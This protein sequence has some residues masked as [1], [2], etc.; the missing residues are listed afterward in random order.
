MTRGV[1]NTGVRHT[2]GRA[3]VLWKEAG[4]RDVS[5]MRA[6][7][8]ARYWW[9]YM[10]LRSCMYSWLQQRLRDDVTY[11]Q[12]QAAFAQAIGVIMCAAGLVQGCRFR[13]RLDWGYRDKE[14]NDRVFGHPKSLHMDRLAQ[15]V[16]VYVVAAGGDVSVASPSN[17]LAVLD[18]LHDIWDQ[19][20]G[21]RRIDDDLGHFSWPWAGQ[22]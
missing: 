2:R 21:S 11:T 19:L 3:P 13:L 6:Q 5:E 16:T 8:S 22:R 10:R 7:S 15:D 9:D 17:S 4:T 20:G 18:S 14:A 12:S 1:P